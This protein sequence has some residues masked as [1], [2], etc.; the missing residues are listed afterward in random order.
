MA[1]SLRIV[2]ARRHCVVKN[3]A[4]GGGQWL[5]LPPGRLKLWVDSFTER[6]HHVSVTGTDYGVRLTAADGAVAECHVPFP[7]L[8]NARPAP[9]TAAQTEP[10]TEPQ[11]P[12]HTEPQT[13]GEA[14]A[15]IV[16]HVTAART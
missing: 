12:P 3:P 10:R 9:E 13:A 2:N 16:S 7:P 14:A 5:E 1:L 11:T 8:P 4:R 15:L 6:H